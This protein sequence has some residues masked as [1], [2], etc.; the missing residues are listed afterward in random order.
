MNLFIASGRLTKD[1]EIFYTQ[2]KKAVARFDLAVNRKFKQEGQPDADFHSCVCFGKT[3]E[4]IDKC[5]V[6]KGTKLLIEGELRNNNYEK[7]GTKYYSSQVVVNSFEF[8]ESKGTSSGTAPQ[9]N[10][11]AEG[12]IPIPDSDLEELPFA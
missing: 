10:D 7:N 1:A 11:V 8:C 4:I 6:K 2:D 5:K 9:N 3:A 12:F